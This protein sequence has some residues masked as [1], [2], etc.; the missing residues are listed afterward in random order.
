[1][2]PDATLHGQCLPTPFLRPQTPCNAKKW[3]AWDCGEA[4]RLQLAFDGALRAVAASAQPGLN[5]VRGP[6]EEGTV[7]E[8]RG[9]RKEGREKCYL[10]C[11]NM[12]KNI[13]IY[14]YCIIY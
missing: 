7:R 10:I 1:M 4:L 3:G 2:H 14:I 9:G 11:C 12:F 6:D 5:R 13:L 8:G